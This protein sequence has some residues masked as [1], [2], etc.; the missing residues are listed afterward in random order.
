MSGKLTITLN[1]GSTVEHYISRP[2]A[3][4]TI[5]DYCYRVADGVLT[6]R[7]GLEGATSYPLTS[8]TS[9]KVGRR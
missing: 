3:N 1:D 9:W 2:D 8:V 7:H 5:G 6:V 4:G